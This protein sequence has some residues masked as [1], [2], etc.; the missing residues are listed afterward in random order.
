VFPVVPGPGSAEKTPKK[1]RSAVGKWGVVRLDFPITA[2]QLLNQMADRKTAGLQASVLP[3]K[4]GRRRPLFRTITDISG[5]AEGKV[6]LLM[7]CVKREPQHLVFY[8]AKGESR[9]IIPGFCLCRIPE[10][11]AN[12]GPERCRGEGRAEAARSAPG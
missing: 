11:R 12:R 7:V 6:P 10:P 2:E 5:A 4:W 8:L 1:R 3:V 9:S